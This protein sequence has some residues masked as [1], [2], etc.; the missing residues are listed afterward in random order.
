MFPAPDP[1]VTVPG[2]TP[3]PT[4]LS[5]KATIG[6]RTSGWDETRFVV[7]PPV[8]GLIKGSFVIS[9]EYGVTVGGE[10]SVLVTDQLTPTTFMFLSFTK[11]IWKVKPTGII[12]VV[13]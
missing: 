7:S 8:E 11:E 3:G 4:R 2:G 13:M 12:S 1:N 9:V 10:V 6:A 5:S